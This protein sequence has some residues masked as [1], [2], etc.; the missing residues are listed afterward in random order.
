MK[1]PS[2]LKEELKKEVDRLNKKLSANYNIFY[3]YRFSGQYMYLDYEGILSEKRARLKYNG[4]MDNW[5]FAIFKW[6]TESYDADEL[7]F[8]GAEELDGTIEGAMK[9]GYLAYK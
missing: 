7:F 9:A 2:H 6:S 4:K 3:T 8:P 5:D 1:I